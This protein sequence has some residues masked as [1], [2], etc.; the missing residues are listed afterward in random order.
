VRLEN[1]SFRY[2]RRGPWVLR[3]VTVSLA[4]GR[5]TEVT[6]HNGAGKSTLLRLTAGLLVPRRGTVTGRPA[7]IGYAPERF[8]ADQPFT[9]RSYLT[10]MAAMR[11][12]PRTAVT[13]WSERL[14]FSDLLDTRLPDLSK[15][16][17]QKVG[18]TQ[19]LLASPE[20]L[21]LDEPFAG[22][23]S[24]TRDDL[25]ALLG[26]LATQGT[27]IVVS[28]HQRSLAPVNALSRVHVAHTTATQTEP[29]TPPDPE[30]WTVVEVLVP[31]AEH[32]QAIAKLRTHGYKIRTPRA[33]TP[34]TTSTTV[35]IPTSAIPATRAT[36]TPPAVPGTVTIP[37]IRTTAVI[38][39]T[40]ATPE[41]P[42]MPWMPGP[43]GYSGH[44]GRRTMIALARF[45]V[46]GYVRSLRVLYP[47]IVVL[48]VVALVLLE[49]PWD[50]TGAAVGTL[51]DVAA[52][53]FP[54]WGWTARALLDTQPDDQ[55]AL[56]DQA[57]GP[58]SAAGLL[59]AYTVNLG[60]GALALA[61]PAA[62]ALSA[63]AGMAALMAGIG[64]HLLVAFAGTVLGAWT[65]RAVLPDAGIS[66]LALIGGVTAALLL[67]L[68]PLSWLAV[69]MLEWLRAAHDSPAAFTSAFPGV[70][71]HL[72]LWTAVAATVYLLI[73][74]RRP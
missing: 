69:P 14:A 38:S 58:S 21:V 7:T 41:M 23:D 19:A 43:S 6:G 56:S 28:D 15:G 66:L 60:F 50:D 71:L 73:K 11:K 42:W 2:D 5:I 39:A 45:Q 33:P 57:V 34:P 53:M 37:A 30:T 25:L 13:T 8:P 36:P 70:A 65:S 26:D 51:G 44:P 27:T 61:V 22:L 24:P 64:L 72:L 18:L 29:R 68:G 48:L 74:Q 16:T 3:D 54:V 4:P 17:A 12:A 55:R 10:H 46:A 62:Q 20:L 31:T 32:K 67:G 52:F 59:A 49:G 9:V 40:S 47:L 63:G 1:V 35:T